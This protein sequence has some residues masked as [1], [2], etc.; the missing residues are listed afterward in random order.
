MKSSNC[1]FLKCSICGELFNPVF[2]SEVA[3]HLHADV[4]FDENGDNE[5][6]EVEQ[7]VAYIK[8]LN[9]HPSK[10][11][12][13][14]HDYHIWRDGEYKGIACWIN[15]YKIGDSFQTLVV[16]Q[17]GTLTNIIWGADKW[18]PVIK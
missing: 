6:L 9:P 10:E 17:D 3:E 13:Y 8:S 14:N 16:K 11:L 5:Y 1:S 15:D 4:E 12:I 7:L 2:L 18:E